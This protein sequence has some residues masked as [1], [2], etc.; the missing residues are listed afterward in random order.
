[1]TPR[2]AGKFFRHQ[3]RETDRYQVE[4]STEQYER[5]RM[6]GRRPTG[7]FVVDMHTGEVVARGFETCSAADAEAFSR[8]RAFEAT[9]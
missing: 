9:Q 8:N 5:D 1:M 7:R 2:H 3:E 6:E 4:Y